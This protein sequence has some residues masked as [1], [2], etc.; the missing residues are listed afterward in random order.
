ME[1]EARG[2]GE[3]REREREEVDGVGRRDDGDRKERLLCIVIK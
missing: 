3:E 2:S 1:R